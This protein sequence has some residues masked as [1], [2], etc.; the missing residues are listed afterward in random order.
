METDIFRVPGEA[1]AVS[2]GLSHSRIFTLWCKNLLVS[3]DHKPLLGILNDRELSAI[4]NPGLQNLKESTFAWDFK[5]AYNPGKWHR[6]ADA[7]S[8][9]PVVMEELNS[10]LSTGGLV[11]PDETQLV[12]EAYQTFLIAHLYD[13]SNGLTSIEH[14]LHVAGPDKEYKDLISIV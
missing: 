4:T 13:M 9:N 6:A 8:R 10:I 3:V 2:W 14:V 7:L 5:I 11:D 12:E 1:F